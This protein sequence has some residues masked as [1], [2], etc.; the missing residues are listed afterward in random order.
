MFTDG[1]VVVLILDSFGM[2]LVKTICKQDT[3]SAGGPS[4]DVSAGKSGALPGRGELCE[5][6]PRKC[7]CAST[8]D[9]EEGLPVRA[10]SAHSVIM[11]EP[12]GVQEQQESTREGRGGGT[13]PGVTAFQDE[14]FR[15]YLLGSGEL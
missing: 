5:L 14:W 4:E 7:W 13:D 1:S 12:V 3:V 9:E 6:D 15:L 10:H 2:C 11:E 8:G